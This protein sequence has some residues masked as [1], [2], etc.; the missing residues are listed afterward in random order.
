MQKQSVVGFDSQTGGQYGQ[1]AREF[2][3]T[4]RQSIM[5]GFQSQSR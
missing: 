5:Q 1:P 4:P 2:A 3:N